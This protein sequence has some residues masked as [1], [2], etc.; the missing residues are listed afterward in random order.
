MGPVEL[1]YKHTE[2]FHQQTNQYKSDFSGNWNTDKYLH[3]I[4]DVLIEK[5][6]EN[7]L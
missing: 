5:G 7:S 3:L 6:P 1:M 2:E 4:R